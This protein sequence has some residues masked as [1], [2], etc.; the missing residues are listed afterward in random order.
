MF[1]NQKTCKLTFFPLECE[2]EPSGGFSGSQISEGGSGAIWKPAATHK[3]DGMG[4]Q[5]HRWDKRE[6]TNPFIFSVDLAS[7]PGCPQINDQTSFEETALL[8]SV[9]RQGIVKF[10]LHLSWSSQMWSQ[11][12][13]KCHFQI[14]VSQFST[15]YNACRSLLLPS[16]RH[17]PPQLHLHCNAISQRCNAAYL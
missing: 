10:C 1:C 4:L 14:L 16:H 15:S 13:W 17:A 6:I 8:F 3:S 2:G 12:S 11:K 7:L 9:S 5:A